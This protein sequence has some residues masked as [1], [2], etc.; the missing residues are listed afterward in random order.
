MVSGEG[1]RPA[2]ERIYK[3]E[4]VHRTGKVVKYLA[5]D[6]LSSRVVQLRAPLGYGKSILLRQLA[7]VAP[8]LGYLPIHIGPGTPFAAI[9][10]QL[11]AGQSPPLLLADSADSLIQ[12]I[13]SARSRVLFLVESADRLAAAGPLQVI[14]QNL[15]DGAD[16]GRCDYVI[17]SFARPDLNL[18]AIR[19]RG[20]VFSLARG[21]LALSVDEVRESLLPFATPDEAVAIY[22]QTLGWPLAVGLVRASIADLVRKERQLGY[23]WVAPVLGE[24]CDTVHDNLIEVLPDAAVETIVEASILGRVPP[25]LRV[26]DG[27]QGVEVVTDYI[28]D[29]DPLVR[30]IP[31]SQQLDINPALQRALV[32]IHVSRHGRPVSE[33]HLA[34]AQA[35]HDEG[36]L[37]DSIYHAR[38]AGRTDLMIEWF[39]KAG[40]PEIGLREG[41]EALRALVKLFS[42]DQIERVPELALS[43]VLL[44]IKEGNLELSRKLL[45]RLR[46][47]FGGGDSQEFPSALSYYVAIIDEVLK[48][49]EDKR[50][51]PDDLS[52]LAQIVEEEKGTSLWSSGIVANILCM[53]YFH[54]GDMGR[55][56]RSARDALDLYTTSRTPYSEVFMH[57]HCAAILSIQGD[58][59]GA[60]RHIDEA[61]DICKTHFPAERGL[62]SLP[63]VLQAEMA[64]DRGDTASAR[65]M[66]EDAVYHLER[67]EGWAELFVR[68]YDTALR[69][70][71]SVDKITEAHAIVERGLQ[72]AATR[73][74][75]RLAS[76]LR[77]RQL[78]I[79]ALH[80]HGR[81]VGLAE[82]LEEAQ[83]RLA[84]P[85]ATFREHY[86]WVSAYAAGCL[87][88]NYPEE[89]RAPLIAALQRQRTEKHEG[90]IVRTLVMLAL[91]QEEADPKGADATF[92][93]A[94]ALAVEHNT[95][96]GLVDFANLT[97]AFA[98]RSVKRGA[99]GG[100]GRQATELLG[101]MIA[102][103]EQSNGARIVTVLS[104][105]EQTVLMQL[106]Q[107]GSNKHIARSLDVTEATVK[108][109]VRNIFDKL[110]VRNR[111]LAIEVARSRGLLG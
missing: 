33:I 17:S 57:V 93:Q 84:E 22:V 72:T 96:R 105:R 83:L 89:A 16:G 77:A 15:L 79:M 74:L 88:L 11:V 18:A 98:R 8:S 6:S 23:D 94:L 69:A 78:E 73:G 30:Q 34:A 9:A 107:G 81:D 10:D 67:Y 52:K 46:Q 38:S 24:L 45:V 41:T 19:A 63:M 32:T 99:V 91:V 42:V 53:A 47:M 101:R 7:G 59:G 110:G 25:G 68:A 36:M 85:D 3:N 43:N 66:I 61:L 5:A 106:S 37:F 102:G 28:R 55:A 103:Q 65:A 60:A 49:Y 71:L 80:E 108:F 50:S 62:V 4:W 35:L 2:L 111:V 39:Q 29:L 92:A 95:L 86:A 104:D 21:E 58:L 70:A 75:D 64:Y 54:I 48:I 90:F 14:L 1:F 20:Q 76:V 44:L 51:S 56:L 13:G 31:G 100:L 97:R 12:M 82:R 26:A 27:L 87:A 40:G 109:H